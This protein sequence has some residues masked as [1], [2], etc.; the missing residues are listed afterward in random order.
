MSACPRCGDRDED[1]GTVCPTCGYAPLDRPKHDIRE[2]LRE[3]FAIDDETAVDDF[4]ERLPQDFVDAL[5][6][7]DRFKESIGLY[8][9]AYS[10]PAGFTSRETLHM[11]VNDLTDDPT[12]DIV[13]WLE[14]ELDPLKDV[15]EVEDDGSDYPL[16]F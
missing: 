14:D 13:A 3:V 16:P 11:L 9:A 5:R 1:P 10:D 4:M 6:I 2:A 15:K 7:I 12:D 8:Q